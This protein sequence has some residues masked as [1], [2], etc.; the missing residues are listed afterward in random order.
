MLRILCLLV[1]FVLWLISMHACVFVCPCMCFLFECFVCCVS[2]EL[3]LVSC[4]LFR[5]HLKI[6]NFII[7][8]PS[9]GILGYLLDLGL[10][11][12]ISC[13]WLSLLP[14]IFVKN[15]FLMRTCMHTPTR[16]QLYTLV[17]TPVLKLNLL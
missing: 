11:C 2:Y 15:L 1:V 5:G 14:P 9:F 8:E 16:S 12:M 3:D 10:L 4:L 7:C 17:L 6:L 13:G